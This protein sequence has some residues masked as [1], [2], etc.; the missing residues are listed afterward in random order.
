[1]DVLICYWHDSADMV[2]TQYYDSTCLGKA[3]V[4]DNFE[5]FGI[6]GLTFNSDSWKKYVKCSCGVGELWFPF[7]QWVLGRTLTGDKK[8]LFCLKGSRLAYYFFIFHVKFSAVCLSWYQWFMG[9][10]DSLELPEMP[11]IT[12]MTGNFTKVTKYLTKFK[13]T[14]INYV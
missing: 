14:L 6:Q 5:K 7:S 8:N 13:E 12:E 2:S 11:E 1:M 4:T 9:Q 10:V 3:A